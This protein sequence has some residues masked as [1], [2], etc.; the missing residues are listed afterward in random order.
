MIWD[1]LSPDSKLSIIREVVAIE[2]KMLLVLFSQYVDFH[3]YPNVQNLTCFS[4][5]IVAYIL[6]EMQ[7][8]V[9]SPLGLSARLYRNLKS[10]Y[11]RRSVLGLLS[12]GTFRRGSL[13][14]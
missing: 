8:K 1:K 4:L 2:L 7:L 14:Q 5:A 11:I 12:I 10:I 13:L 3:I 9:Q 6:R